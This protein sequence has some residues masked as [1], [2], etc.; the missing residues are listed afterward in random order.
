MPRG[1]RPCRPFWKTDLVWLSVAVGKVATFAA[2]VCRIS[3]DL[4]RVGTYPEPKK[5]CTAAAKRPEI[6]TWADGRAAFEV[7]PD[8]VKEE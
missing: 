6:I 3:L 8:T 2:P 5:L 4:G 7:V 1:Y